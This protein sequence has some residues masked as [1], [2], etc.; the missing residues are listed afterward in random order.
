MTPGLSIITPAWKV[1]DFISDY[2]RSFYKQGWIKKNENW[3]IMIGVDGCKE[4]L[5]EF[6]KRVQKNTRIFW[7]PK[8]VGPYL[9]RNTLAYKAAYSK[10]LFFDADD[11][12]GK[13]LISDIMINFEK[14]L[15]TFTM[16]RFPGPPR[17]KGT[18]GQF[19]IDKSLFQSF[20]G[21]LP[22]RVEADSEFLGRLKRNGIERIRLR[23][24]VDVLRRRHKHQ[25][26]RMSSTGSKSQL[27]SG[28]RKIKKEGWKKGLKEIVPCFAECIEI[29]NPKGIAS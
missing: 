21:F 20:G 5:R 18:V 1:K 19:A 23:D 28:L 16:E 25:L 29:E 4:S 11:I 22:W 17:R 14:S 15:I 8:N 7:F 9:I 10:L 24:Q 2:L 27:R 3:E 6:K 12:A 13:E 26:T